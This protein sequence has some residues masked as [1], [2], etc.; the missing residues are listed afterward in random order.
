MF[1]PP[2]HVS[3]PMPSPAPHRALRVAMVTVLC[4]IVT[5]ICI[6]A[7]SLPKPP[8]VADEILS[9]A[10]ITDVRL[11]IAPLPPLLTKAGKSADQIMAVSEKILED[12]GYTVVGHAAAPRL[13]VTIFTVTRESLKNVVAVTATIDVYQDVS[14]H[15]LKMDLTVPTMT[16]VITDL[17]ASSR[18]DD[19][20]TKLCY[21][22][23]NLLL[24]TFDMATDTLRS[25]ERAD[26]P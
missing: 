24:K 12:S 4:V 26:S 7:P 9:T 13:V 1:S 10:E 14:V 19:S 23:F 21:Q 5:A 6:A 11:A 20:V 8:P 2:R 16:I 25:Q 17:A 3:K 22:A 15:R 18:L